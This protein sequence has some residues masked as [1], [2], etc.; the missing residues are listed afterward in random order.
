[1]Q[2]SYNQSLNYTGQPKRNF[3]MI[4]ILI[5]VIVALIVVIVAA[6][7]IHKSQFRVTST[8]PNLDN[9]SLLTPDVTLTFSK[10]V[11]PDG[12]NVTSVPDIIQ[13]VKVNGKKWLLTLSHR[14][15][16]A[17]STRLPW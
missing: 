5:I 10:D 4:K 6:T 7:V 14:L 13:S 16:L 12:L 1:M 8:T 11:A 17:P 15:M 3:S 2:P 9:V